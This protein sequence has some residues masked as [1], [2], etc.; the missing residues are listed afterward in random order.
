M[1]ALLGINETT[2][3]F[4]DA[5]LE[6]LGQGVA[7]G[8]IATDEIQYWIETHENPPTPTTQPVKR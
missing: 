1:L 5:E 8:T 3:A 4:T 6:S 2:L 7:D